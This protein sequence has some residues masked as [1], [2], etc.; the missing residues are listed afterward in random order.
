[1]AQREMVTP[2]PDNLKGRKRK[3]V[4]ITHLLTSIHAL[5]HEPPCYS[6]NFF[7]VVNSFF[8]KTVDY[9]LEEYLKNKRYLVVSL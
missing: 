6:K 7:N 2:K 9:S 8:L 4:P 3:M 1:M 5:W